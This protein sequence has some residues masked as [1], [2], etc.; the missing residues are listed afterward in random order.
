MKFFDYIYAIKN[1][2]HN[3]IFYFYSIRNYFVSRPVWFY[4][5]NNDLI[6]KSEQIIKLIELKEPPTILDLGCGNGIML[7]PY[8]KLTKPE[9][10]FGVDKSYINIHQCSQNLIPVPKNNFIYGNIET[11]IKDTNKTFDIILLHGVIGYFTYEKQNSI[12]SD[13]I[14][15][16]NKN[17][18]IILGAVNYI[19]DDYIFQTYPLKNITI[20][21]NFCSSNNLTYN[22]YND[23]ELELV[24]KYNGKT[25]IIRK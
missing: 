4:Y 25:I 21:D 3:M 24:P 18:Y 14:K 5:T 12:L 17:G 23:S 16:L 11:F 8:L 10:I 9:N 13:C 6:H 22:V 20:I 1:Y 7:Q 19:N 15:K 2:V